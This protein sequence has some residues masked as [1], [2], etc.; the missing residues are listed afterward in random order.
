MKKR[1]AKKDQ[2]LRARVL[3]AFYA[4]IPSNTGDL[5][6]LINDGPMLDAAA[7]RGDFAAVGADIRHAMRKVDHE[8]QVQ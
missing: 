5:S 1:K 8:Q 3:R 2:E 4:F 7:I 6:R